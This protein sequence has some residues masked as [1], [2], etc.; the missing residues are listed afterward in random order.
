M[1][2][3]TENYVTDFVDD[4]YA[5]LAKQYQLQVSTFL[6]GRISLQTGTNC[7]DGQIVSDH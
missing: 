7:L 1:I 6:V 3:I 4:S 5:N 2:R